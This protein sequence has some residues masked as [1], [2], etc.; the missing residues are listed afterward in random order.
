MACNGTPSV[1]LGF[2]M[3][4]ILSYQPPVDSQRFS[5]GFLSLAVDL[6]CHGAAL[7]EICGRACVLVAKCEKPPIP[8]K[9]QD[10]KKDRNRDP[11]VLKKTLSV[12][13]NGSY[14]PVFS[15]CNLRLMA[16]NKRCGGACF[17]AGSSL[18]LS[19]PNINSGTLCQG[20]AFVPELWSRFST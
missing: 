4:S 14:I 15:N 2:L 9:A 20:S 19:P 1:S 11:S 10:H 12:N 8:R 5:L 17:S 3:L 6:V 16:S 7:R 13:N 18:W